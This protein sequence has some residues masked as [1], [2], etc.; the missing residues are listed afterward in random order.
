[1][2]CANATATQIACYCVFLVFLSEIHGSSK[3]YVK[4]TQKTSCYDMNILV[5]EM[6]I[7]ITP[8]VAVSFLHD[9]YS[10]FVVE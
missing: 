9:I 8:C 6:N 10:V 1:M 4:R 5:K 3:T 2:E 7:L